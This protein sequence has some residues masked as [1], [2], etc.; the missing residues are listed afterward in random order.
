LLLLFKGCR[1]PCVLPGLHRLSTSSCIIT[2]S[3]HLFLHPARVP[4]VL[5]SGHASAVAGS[6][7]ANPQDE[8]L[9]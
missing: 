8:F 4:R 2:P 6:M 3:L 1:P 5:V 9:L 7:A